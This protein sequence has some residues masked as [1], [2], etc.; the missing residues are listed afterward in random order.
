MVRAVPDI[1][2]RGLGGKHFFVQRVEGSDEKIYPRGG[3]L[4]QKNLVWVCPVGKFLV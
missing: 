1:I 2:L 3:G 4:E